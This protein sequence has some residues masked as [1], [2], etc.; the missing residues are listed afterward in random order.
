MREGGGEREGRGESEERGERRDEVRREG[1]RGED[2]IACTSIVFPSSHWTVGG[3]TA[4]ATQRSK[5]IMSESTLTTRGFS[6]VP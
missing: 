4:I 6:H 2:S 5:K 1:G 3:G